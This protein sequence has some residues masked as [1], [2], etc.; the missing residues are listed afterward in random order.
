MTLSIVS[1]LY[2]SRPFLDTFIKEIMLAIE[3]TGVSE[4]ELIFVNDGSPDDSVAHLLQH[5]LQIPQIKI[6]DLSRNYGHHYAIQAGLEI[7]KGDYVFLIDNDLEVHPNVLAQF[8]THIKANPQLDVVYGFQEAR[9]GGFTEN[10]AG[11]IFWNVINY[12]S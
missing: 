12:L 5:Q 10:Y 2:R 3:Q 8:Y 6:V 7:S 4:Y 9:K 11:K 1:T